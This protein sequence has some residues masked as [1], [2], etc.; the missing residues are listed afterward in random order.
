MQIGLPVLGQIGEQREKHEAA[1][2]GDGVIKAQCLQP[3]IDRAFDA[4]IAIHAGCSDIF[5]LPE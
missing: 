5:G 1:D 4:T 2:E 3:G